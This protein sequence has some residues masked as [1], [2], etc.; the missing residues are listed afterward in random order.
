MHLTLIESRCTEKPEEIK[1]KI[2]AN[3]LIKT[4]QILGEKPTKSEVDLMIWVIILSL[5]CLQE[6]DDDLDKHVS[7]I[8]FEKMYK[9]C[10]SDESGLEP[11]KLYN[12]VVFLMYDKEFK[13]RVTVEDTLQL[14]YVRYGRERLDDEIQA[15]FGENEKTNEGNEKFIE[16]HEYI[17]KIN[18]RA[19]EERKKRKA[20]VKQKWAKI[21]EGSLNGHDHSRM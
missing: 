11:R 10:I 8:E 14:L 7:K 1:E 3:D 2:S 6:V 17:E 19:M 15:I 20:A 4:L 12:L 16:Y 13:G 18:H 21:N 5:T 9:R